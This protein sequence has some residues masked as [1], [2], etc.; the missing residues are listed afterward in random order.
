MLTLILSTSAAIAD[1]QKNAL[2]KAEYESMSKTL[3]TK[4]GDTV[5]HTGK[6]VL[7]IA[8]TSSYYYDPQTYYIDSLENDPDGKRMLREA[9]EAALQKSKNTGGDWFKLRD[10]M[11]IS[12]KGR[13]KCLKDFS[14]GKITAWDANMGDRYRYEVDMDDLKWELG[15]S[16]KNV[17]GYDCQLARADYH[18]RKWIAWFTPELGVTDGPWQLCGLPGLIMEAVTA[19]GEY[20][21]TIKGLQQCDEPLKDPYEEK[22]KIFVTKRIAVLRAKDYSR[23]NRAAQISAM[24]GGAVKLKPTVYKENIDFI[25]TDYHEKK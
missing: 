9:D 20:G 10:E 16:T 6:Y 8:P 24:T 11:G 12:R 13:Y 3:N 1:N 19:D 18:G 14:T 4:T 7:Q 22:D 2:L 15:D 5:T 17:L 21:F 23:R 25:E